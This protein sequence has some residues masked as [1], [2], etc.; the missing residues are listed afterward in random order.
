M[1]EAIGRYQIKKEI[2]GEK[3][4]RPI[5]LAHDPLINRAVGV[6]LYPIPIGIDPLSLVPEILTLAKLDHPALIPIYDVNVHKQ[7]IYVVTREPETVS[8]RALIDEKSLS[9]AD[10]LNIFESLGDGLDRLAQFNYLPAPF[11]P[12]HV[13]LDQNRRPI[14]DY[15]S[16]AFFALNFL[17]AISPEDENG[18]EDGPD[19]TYTLS[20]IL[21]ETVTGTAPQTDGGH[22][23]SVDDSGSSSEPAKVTT[24]SVIPEPVMQV[25]ERGVTEEIN[26][27]YPN[28]MALVNSF[29]AAV[30]E[31]F[32]PADIQAIKPLEAPAAPQPDPLEL[33]DL[34]EFG[35]EQPGGRTP[36]GAGRVR[37][38]SIIIGAIVLLTIFGIGFFLFGPNGIMREPTVIRITATPAPAIIAPTGTPSPALTQTPTDRDIPPT[39][40]PAT[41]TAQPTA[42]P[43][44]LATATP[45]ASETPR[46]TASQ[47]PTQPA[48]LTRTTTPTASPTPDRPPPT[49][50]PLF[51]V[52]PSSVNVRSGP[53]PEYEALGFALEDQALEIL[54]KTPDGSWLF[55]RTPEDLFGWVNRLVGRIDSTNTL[56]DIPLA[57]TLPAPP[58]TVP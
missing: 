41:A 35:V 38:S 47:T 32:D 21:Y 46:S 13:R 42:T 25:L 31:S 6:A 55:V 44:D 34:S 52:E 12:I 56:E 8:L 10:I 19:Y 37:S 3:E 9:Y 39:Q 40:S 54:A 36:N 26:A 17:P 1:E 22:R 48:T 43:T 7:Q 15:L 30:E 11:T 29:R 51:F 27:R 5:F 20:S 57:V 23:L 24:A 18:D 16:S 49:P 28:G 50:I 33:I 4:K 53:S 45:Q 58:T 2:T 14:L